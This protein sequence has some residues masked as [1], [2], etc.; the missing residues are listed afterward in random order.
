MSIFGSDRCYLSPR[1]SIAH[2]QT[3]KATLDRKMA[4][5]LFLAHRIP[6][7]P[8]KGDKLRAYHLLNHWAKQH[9]VF[10]GCFVDDPRICSIVIGCASDAPDTYFARLHP[11][12][13]GHARFHWL[14]HPESHEC[15]LLS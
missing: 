5:I 2:A 13:R 14:S 4:T 9:K 11:Q 1:S 6:Y 12:A 8:N 10:L 7:P 3:A 15:P